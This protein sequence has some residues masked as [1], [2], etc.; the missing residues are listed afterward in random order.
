M[1]CPLG[2]SRR[3]GR[4]NKAPVPAN[5]SSTSPGDPNAAGA[6]AGGVAGTGSG[7][8][9]N[10]STGEG[11]GSDGGGSSAAAAAAAAAAVQSPEGRPSSEF[12]MYAHTDLGGNLP[13]S[14]INKLCKKPAYRVLRKVCF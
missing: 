5:G 14:V 12:T 9:G 1:I 8:D 7:G 4:I 10:S 2:E 13:A 3:R 6:A 11:G